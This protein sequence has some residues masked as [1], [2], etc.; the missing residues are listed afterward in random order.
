MSPS[1]DEIGAELA[2]L[3]KKGRDELPRVTEQ[4]AGASGKIG[5]FM[6]AGPLHRD[7]SLGL[8]DNG[9]YEDFSTVRAALN[10][11]LG[12]IESQL[13]T[14][15]VNIMKTAQDMANV[16]QATAGAFN[17]HGGEL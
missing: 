3:Y 9:P 12:D 16:D 1:P 11:R 2:E 17:R 13:E 10:D 8:G 5:S 4:F 14:I 6:I 7:G 15:G